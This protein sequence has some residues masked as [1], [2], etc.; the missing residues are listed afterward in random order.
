MD[1]L[2]EVE[3]TSSMAFGSDGQTALNEILQVAKAIKEG[4]GGV[5]GDASRAT[6]AW[7]QAI[8][9]VNEMAES[10]EAPISD[11]VAMLRRIVL[12]DF[13]SKAKGTYPGLCGE[14][15][16][17]IG[18]ASSKFVTLQDA[19]EEISKGDLSRLE[20]F[21]AIGNG[22]GRRCEQDRLLP[23]FIRMM[24]NLNLVIS[25]TEKMYEAHK[26]GDSDFTIDASKFQGEY[27]TL[28]ESIDAGFAV[29]VTEFRAVLDILA[30]YA[31]GDFSPVM[32][33]LPGKHARISDHMDQI[34]GTLLE[35]SSELV[36]L[37]EA[38]LGGKLDYR[39]DASKFSGEFLK[40]VDGV[41]NTL[42]AIVTPVKEA[43]SVLTTMAND[44][45]T[46]KVKGE[47]H[48]DHALIKNS[49]NTAIDSLAGLV[50]Q[51]IDAVEQIGSAS[52]QISSSAQTVA[53]GASE[54]ASSLEE[55]SSSLEEIAGMTKNNAENAANALGLA[56]EEAGALDD[57][58]NALD[59]MV[60]AIQDIKASSDQ[61]AKV[62]KTI[63]DIAFQTN[64]LALNAAVEAARAGE[65]G[66]GFAVVSEEVRNL[67]LRSAEA[68][69]TTA[70]MID[71]SVKKADNGVITVKE[72]ADALHKV[73]E[74]ATKVGQLV[75]EIAA[76]SEEQAKAS[77]Q[78]SVATTQM[79]KVTQA[80]AS[81]AEESA[82]A[83]EE[84][85]SQARM[86]EEMVSNFKVSRSARKAGRDAGELL[87]GL[88]LATLQQL[89]E[90]AKRSK[91]VSHETRHTNSPVKQRSKAGGRD[92]RAKF[93]LDESEF[94]EF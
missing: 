92:A 69:K 45:L 43:A 33:R 87:S 83:A 75:T 65:A 46:A 91:G 48:G 61:T 14:L 21:K 93:P 66:R 68:A 28:V 70:G 54:Q 24:E 10:F 78:V 30:A 5:R 64:L 71:E 39:A 19:A 44:D 35:V 20:A 79:D 37:V 31:E 22:A 80:N 23:A 88:D 34:R 29:Y 76:A 67:A 74:V 82:S 49:L 59:R 42:D 27:R 53:E 50:I 63:D 90:D 58:R 55:V 11:G 89:I 72:V 3:R 62:V 94:A 6:G 86:L 51:V 18:D 36:H 26:A 8:E 7:A 41:N 2:A 40:I 4:K 47:Y 9:A 32:M 77:E 52:N 56:Q 1:S 17:L 16:A 84:L 57:G 38:A 15:V 85:S 25:W 60:A 12:N 81:S 73:R 13:T